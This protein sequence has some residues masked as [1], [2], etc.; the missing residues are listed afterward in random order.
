M[1]KSG[2]LYQHDRVKKGA[3]LCPAE[4]DVKF[5]VYLQD[6]TEQKRIFSENNVTVRPDEVSTTTVAMR[7]SDLPPE[8]D[9]PSPHARVFV[10]LVVETVGHMPHFRKEVSLL[11]NLRPGY[12]FVQSDKPLYTPHQTGKHA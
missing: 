11:V 8:P 4:Y 10:S 12:I 6:Q 1:A 2:N 9:P 7:V 3:S 5:R